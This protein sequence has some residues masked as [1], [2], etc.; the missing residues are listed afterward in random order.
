MPSAAAQR[1]IGKMV[2]VAKLRRTAISSI[3][4]NAI[5]DEAQSNPVAQKNHRGISAMFFTVR[6]NQGLGD[7]IGIIPNAAGNAQ[8]PLKRFHHGNVA[9]PEGRAPGNFPGNRV[10]NALHRNADAG[11]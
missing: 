7:H 8:N 3:I 6:G 11:D 4:D 1:A 2:H 10:G 9:G 5:E